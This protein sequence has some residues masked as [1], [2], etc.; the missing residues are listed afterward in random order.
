MLLLL[1]P[2]GSCQL[3]LGLNF[4]FARRFGFF[5]R[6]DGLL[7]L[8]L[9]LALL[10]LLL[11]DLLLALH[12]GLLALF[13][14]R[15]DLLLSLALALLLLTTALGGFLPLFLTFKRAVHIVFKFE[16]NAM[17]QLDVEEGSLVDV[18]LDEN[19]IVTVLAST[20]RGKSS[21]LRRGC[22][23]RKHTLAW[24]R[25]CLLDCALSSHRSIRLGLL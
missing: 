11:L 18:C 2:V 13:L 9:F 12:V 24:D 15:L 19:V 8:E 14:G 7:V 17:G 16:L 21:L 25:S 5:L 10:L 23:R 22:S 20:H 3:L 6:S 1:R 4:L